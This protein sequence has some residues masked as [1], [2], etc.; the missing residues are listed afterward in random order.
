MLEGQGDTGRSRVR[1]VLKEK[2]LPVQDDVSSLIPNLDPPG[3][4]LGLLVAIMIHGL[5]G[6]VGVL[7]PLELG[8][9]DLPLTVAEHDGLVT[10][11]G[12]ENKLVSG[13]HL[14]WGPVGPRDVTT[15][16]CTPHPQILVDRGTDPARVG[17]AQ[18]PAESG[19]RQELSR[20]NGGLGR[21]QERGRG[22]GPVPAELL[23][24]H[25]KVALREEGEAAG[26]HP[27][28]GALRRDHPG[29]I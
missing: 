29:R 9:V 19:Y 26:L 7:P 16:V 10:I 11:P 12:G 8:R 21:A 23:A 20:A 18:A 13:Q 4:V 25:R 14:P 2:L 24:G 1:L 3:G 22:H 28:R 5:G 27:G 17:A 6:A 15:Q